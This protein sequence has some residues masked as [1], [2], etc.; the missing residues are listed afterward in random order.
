GFFLIT[1]Y[2]V[3]WTFLSEKITPV[4]IIS[5]FLALVGLFLTFG[6]SMAVFSASALFLAALN[7]VGSGGEIAT[8]KKSTEHYSSFQITFY[9]WLLILATHL[10]LSLL[11]GESQVAPAFNVEWMS[12]LCYAAAGLAG[13]WLV[14]EGFKY[15]DASIG[16]LIGLL[17]IPLSA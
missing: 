16:G 14:I 4:K 11:T 7:G 1:T 17:E 3:G 2:G 10:P 15:V 8:S 12:M 9:S 13:F 6:W 5:L